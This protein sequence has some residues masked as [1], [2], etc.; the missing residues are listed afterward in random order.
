VLGA[1]QER[2]GLRLEVLDADA[3]VGR[4]DARREDHHVGVVAGVVLL[5]ELAEPGV[6]ALVGG[7][8]G[9]A[10]AQPGICLSH[11]DEPAQDEVELDRHRLLT[12]QRAV[13]V[14]HGQ[15]ILD[16]NRRRPV[17][18]GRAS[19]ER[20]DRLLGRTVAP[21]RQRSRDAHHVLR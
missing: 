18:A 17:L 13:V 21:A 19:D 6:V 12:P 15:A 10:L 2:V 16:G 9:L 4:E 5:H 20:A 1:A 3:V 7:L 8:P 14:E 11:L